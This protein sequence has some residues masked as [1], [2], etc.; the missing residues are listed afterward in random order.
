M[1]Q[2]T[3]KTL[4]EKDIKQFLKFAFKI[5]KDDPNWVPP[6]FMDRMKM[7]NKNK[8]PFFNE[9]GGDMELFMAYRNNE[10]VGRIAA[11]KND[12]HNNIHNENIGF[13]GF[14]ECINDQ[15]VANKLLDTA[16]DWLK[17]FNFNAMR[18]PTN[19]T[20]SDE[21]GALLE[22]FNDTPRILMAYNPKY[23]LDLFDG[24][25][26][27]KVKDL[28][29]Y[30]IQNSDMK[31]NEKIKRVAD[32]VKKR[33]DIKIR[34]INMKKF[35]DELEVFKTIWN[36]TWVANWGFIPMSESEIEAAAA[37]LKQLVNPDLVFFAE[38][39]NEVIGVVLAMPD[40]NQ[41]FRSMKGRLFPFQFLKLF[42]QKKKITWA[43]VIALGV[44]PEYQKKG[45]DGALYYEC[46]VRAAKH[47]IM[48][49]EASWI[50]EDNLM[51]NRGAETMQGKIYKKYRIYEKAI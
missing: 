23:Y 13:F 43:R 10:P 11:I 32:I 30:S 41:I 9:G 45:I 5:Y 26:L 4:S 38:I 18:G 37:D 21:Y 24:Y 36:K 1:D 34:S 29:A 2:I 27:E 33:Y 3:V 42:T 14:F 15:K 7:L 49:G 25:G 31:K 47:G 46:M 22:G 8:N 12:V 44:I 19:P 20:S 39:K 48:Q 17:K 6:L 35:Q 50:L 28:Y 40:Y 16:Q 51:M